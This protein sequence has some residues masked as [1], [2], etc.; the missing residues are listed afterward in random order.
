M[1]IDAHIHLDDKRFME[2]LGVPTPKNMVDVEGYLDVQSRAGI[3]FSVFSGPR[4]QEVG[5]E[6]GLDPVDVAREYNDFAAELTARH[7]DRLLG[8]GQAYPMG[9]EPML[10]EME[11]AVRDLGLRGFLIATAYED[12]MIDDPEAFPF[13]ELCQELDVVAFVHNRGNPIGREHMADH[14]LVELV[15]NPNEM[16]LAA[17]RLIFTGVMERLPDLKLF[18]GRLGGAITTYAGRIQVG[19]ETRHSRDASKNGGKVPPWG[20][21]KL[22]G[23]FMDSLRRIHVCTQTFHAPAIAG[24]IDTLGEDRVL[25]GTDYPPVPRDLDLSVQDVREAGVTGASLDKVMRENAVRLF[26]LPA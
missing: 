8:L 17:A 9:G 1:F 23:S 22:T 2:R 7:P 25:F 16:T 18:L 14:R 11:R 24:A 5:A 4:I 12:R 13:F 3:G 6:A 26:G 20:P 21:D 19:W 10:R 15:G